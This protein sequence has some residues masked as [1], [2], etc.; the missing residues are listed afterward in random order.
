MKVQK[1]TKYFPFSMYSVDITIVLHRLLHSIIVHYKYQLRAYERSVIALT[2]PILLFLK[3]NVILAKENKEML[4]VNEML[5][6][7]LYS[8]KKEKTNHTEMILL[9]HNFL[10]SNIVVF[11]VTFC[12]F[13]CSNN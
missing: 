5:N 2:F 7:H 3:N 11:K 13:F 8:I 6:L 12:T 4:F 1:L 9:T 10:L